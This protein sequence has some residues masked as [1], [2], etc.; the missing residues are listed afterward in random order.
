[1]NIIVVTGELA[2]PTAKKIAKKSKE[3]VIVHV[4]ETQIA[5][6]LT[7]RKIIKELKEKRRKE[8]K[9][10]DIILT[11]GLMKKSA[12]EIKEELKIPT[13]KGPRDVADLGFVIEILNKIELSTT[14]AADKL[15]EEEKLKNALKFIEKFEND[16]KTIQKLLEK[17]HNIKV[18]NLPVG[19]D[20]PMRVLGEIANAPLLSEEELIWK[21]NYFLDNG[22]DMIDIG[23]VAG[24]DYSHKIPELISILRKEIG[25][26]PL[27][28]DTLSPNEIKIAIENN[29]DLVLSLDLGNCDELIPLLKNKNIPA[30]LL[31][32]DFKKNIVPHTPDERISTMEK[33]MEKAKSIEFFGDLILDP[34]NSISIVDSI[35]AC[36]KFK[37]THPYPLFFGVGN[38]S[39]LLDADST[40][41]NALISGI[42]ME[43]RAS[44]LFTP[45]ES[46]K[47]WNSVYELAIAS[48]MMFLAKHRGS[49]AKDLGINL[50][51]FKDRK[52]HQYEEIKVEIEESEKLS[53]KI[54]T[55]I[56]N[57][58]PK[59]VMDKKGSFK[60]KVEHGT[61]YDKSK[62]VV[63]HYKKGNPTLIIEGHSASKIYNEILKKELISRFEHG[64]YLGSELQKAEIAMIQSKEYI[65]DFELFKKPFILE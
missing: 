48:K 7:P 21:C 14:E 50:I 30:V 60:I 65:Q 22:A 24:E 25:D 15:I 53:Q 55:T 2:S 12:D 39:E 56:A 45:D 58:E 43:L 42:A 16:E 38:V 19:E 40:G 10:A 47:C 23:M 49:I 28:I 17:P 44:V 54:P 1:M 35:I 61:R 13:F 59:F 6:F 57:K 64:A 5:A 37:E 26:K 33:L 36:K 8:L 41:L 3:N 31:P 29:I 52:K 62:I 9:E 27:S 20:F 34:V 46:G 51:T 32:T 63:T 4:A 18:R 11:P